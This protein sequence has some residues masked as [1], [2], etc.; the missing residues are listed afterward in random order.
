MKRLILFLLCLCL[1]TPA[2]AEIERTPN[3]CGDGCTVWWPKLTLPV[4]WQQ[5]KAT[6]IQ[7]NLN[8]LVPKDQPVSDNSAFMYATATL[9]VDPSS[10]LDDF[11][12]ADM[13]G[14]YRKDPDMKTVEQ[15]TL[16]TADGQTLQ[17]F[18]FD[19]GKAGGRWEAA[20]YGMETDP[21]GD[22]YFL[23]FVVSGVDQ[24]RRDDNMAAF[25]G[26]ILNYRK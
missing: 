23:T 12:V 3:A 18:T 14:F 2:L 19:P 1:A 8:F 22:V 10:K 4:G 17:V 13:T 15:P 9:A 5:D 20:A 24:A 26:I 21:D 11:V 7:D 25:R 6:S 16:T